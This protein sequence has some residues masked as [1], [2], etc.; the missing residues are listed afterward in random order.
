MGSMSYCLFEN[1]LGEFSRCVER[2]EEASS[3]KDLDFNE[4]ELR[5]FH[6]MWRVARDFLAEH[7]RLLSTECEEELE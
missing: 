4:Y 6:E 1:T 2:M 5:A 3:L 7:E